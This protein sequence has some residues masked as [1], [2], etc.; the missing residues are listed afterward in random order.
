[1]VFLRAKV[2]MREN[3][4]ITKFVRLG[5]VQPQS[6]SVWEELVS[7]LHQLVLTTLQVT[8][9]GEFSIFYE[10]TRAVYPEPW[11]SFVAATSGFVHASIGPASGAYGAAG[12]RYACDW[13]PSGAGGFFPLDTVG[14]ALVHDLS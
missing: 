11:N 5:E 4:H 13:S 3:H 8:T 14:V 1:M 6:D 7:R 2:T 12:C 9:T 10:S